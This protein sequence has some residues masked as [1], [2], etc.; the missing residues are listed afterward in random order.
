LPVLPIQ[1]VVA[2]Y[3]TLFVYV[4]EGWEVL[5]ATPYHTVVVSLDAVPEVVF[6]VLGEAVTGTAA[7]LILPL[8][9]ALLCG[10]VGPAPK[11]PRLSTR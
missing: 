3:V 6:R 9:A 2:V 1:L 8:I 7:N 5:A 10:E 11:P 4:P